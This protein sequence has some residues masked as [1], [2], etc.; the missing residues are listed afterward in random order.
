M[1]LRHHFKIELARAR[2]GGWPCELDETITKH[3]TIRENGSCCCGGIPKIRIAM[4][5]GR[6]NKTNFRVQP[7]QEVLQISNVNAQVDKCQKSFA[8][9]SVKGMLEI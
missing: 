1:D 7:K 4:A 9:H 3:K 6:Y 5:M 2:R 8:S